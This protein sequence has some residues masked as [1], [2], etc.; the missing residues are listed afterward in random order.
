MA[1]VHHHVQVARRGWRDLA[2]RIHIVDD[3]VDGERARFRQA[4][5]EFEDAVHAV[6]HPSKP[7]FRPRSPIHDQANSLTATTWK[8]FHPM[9]RHEKANGHSSTTSHRKTHKQVVH[10]LLDGYTNASLKATKIQATIRTTIQELA[11]STIMCLQSVADGDRHA[12]GLDIA[13]GFWTELTKKSLHL[14]W[15]LLEKARLLD[16]RRN[17]F[18]MCVANNNGKVFQGALHEHHGPLLEVAT[19]MLHVIGST[20]ERL[21]TVATEKR[22]DDD[23]RPNQNVAGQTMDGPVNISSTVVTLFTIMHAYDLVREIVSKFE[24]VIDFVDS[25]QP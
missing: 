5:S 23:A 9:R 18:A 15:Y 8:R 3:A 6:R 1:L 10:D 19:T 11:R 22:Q 16:H 25:L 12:N 4:C 14:R 21:A 24:D 7:R 17:Q 13:S 2:N 20:V